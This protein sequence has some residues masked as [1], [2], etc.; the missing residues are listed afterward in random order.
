MRL[1][2]IALVGGD[3]EAARDEIVDVLGLGGAYADPGVGKYGLSNQVWPIGDTFLEVVSPRQDGTTAGR[4]L[5]KRGGDGGYMVILQ[6]EDL[7]GARARLAD[8]GVR[9]VDQ[10]DGEGVHFTHLHPK[11]VGGAILSIDA[12]VPPSRW[13]WGGPDWEANVRTE[14]STGI[15]G[16]ELQGA[17][18]DAMS[19]RWAAVLGR[20]RAPAGE[21]WR[22]PLEGGELRFSPDRD[23]RGDG[24]KGFDVAV[25]DPDGVRSRASARGT[26]DAE[27]EV[28]L[29]GARV[30]LVKDRAV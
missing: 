17:D 28:V 22:I 29:C 23:G 6:T 14:V 13:Q 27:G 30:W 3:L 9:V 12:M 18:P 8:Q 20:P 16:A 2:Q 11:D 5:D 1:R 25:R 10:F 19:A 15:V 7:P 26:L 4:L 24:L 21:G